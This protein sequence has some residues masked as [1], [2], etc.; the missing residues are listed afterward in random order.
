[1]RNH[2]S[3]TGIDWKSGKIHNS[4][5]HQ[6]K[7]I[8]IS[9]WFKPQQKDWSEMCKKWNSTIF[10][11]I[12]YLS[13]PRLYNFEERFFFFWDKKEL[14]D[15]FTNYANEI[16]VVSILDEMQLDPVLPTY[17]HFFEQWT[18]PVATIK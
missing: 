15:Q 7:N 12:G 16:L 9:S 14:L 2:R 17:V 8:Y 1:M 10:L 3:G 13:I 11:G 5:S 18:N 4:N 6:K